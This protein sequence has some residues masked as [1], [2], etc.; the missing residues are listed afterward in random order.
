LGSPSAARD[1]EAK[2]LEVALSA[3]QREAL[4]QRIA[5]PDVPATS[6]VG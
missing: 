5:S 2:S 6:E 1:F 4:R 3:S